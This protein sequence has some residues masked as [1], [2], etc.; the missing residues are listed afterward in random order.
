MGRSRRRS[1]ASSYPNMSF[2]RSNRFRSSCS[3]SSRA[4]LEL[5]LRQHLRQLIEQLPLFLGELLR[6]L[7]LDGGE[8]IAASTAVDVGHALAAQPQRRAGLRAFRYLHR[9]GAVERRNLNFPAK[10]HGREVDWNFAE[11]VV[12]VAPEELVLV[13]VDDDVKMTG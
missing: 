2:T 4:R 12:P 8:E 10:R 9:L 13:H 1:P 11:Q 6:C 7:H 5:L 3:C